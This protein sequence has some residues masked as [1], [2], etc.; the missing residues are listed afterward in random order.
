MHRYRPSWNSMP[1]NSWMT[2]NRL[3]SAST[4]QKWLALSNNKRINKGLDLNKFGLKPSI[5]SGPGYTMVDLV[6]EGDP[7]VGVNRIYL[8]FAEQVV[9]AHFLK[10][11]ELHGIE[12]DDFLG[13]QKV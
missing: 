8:L 3:T 10:P 4:T 6:I 1:K 7:L 13:P 5:V 9:V 2:Q 11:F 12:R